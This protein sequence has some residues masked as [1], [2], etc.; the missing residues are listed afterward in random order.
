MS[1]WTCTRRRHTQAT[2]DAAA[3]TGHSWS[4]SRRRS[5][6]QQQQQ[7][8]GESNVAALQANASPNSQAPLSTNPCTRPSTSLCGGA[9]RLNNHTPS[10]CMSS[11]GQPTLYVDVIRPV[12]QLHRGMRTLGL[13]QRL[14][15]P[16][17]VPH[18]LPNKTPTWGPPHANSHRRDPPTKCYKQGWH[19]VTDTVLY[20]ARLI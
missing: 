9:Q 17:V 19:Q 15:R 11:L 6:E 3:V 16:P 18:S 1:C 7:R 10:L 14:S 8:C 20:N 5:E 12:L 13:L 4:M 2:R